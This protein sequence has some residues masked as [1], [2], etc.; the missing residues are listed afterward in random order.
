MMTDYG[1]HAS[2]LVTVA[3]TG[4]TLD[5]VAALLDCN[6]G[7]A[8]YCPACRRWADLDLARLVAQ[9]RGRRRLQGFRPC[10]RKCGQ[11]GQ[12]Q[13]RPPKPTWPSGVTYIGIRDVD[14]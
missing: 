12:I 13:I 7:L 1:L 4:V 8:A 10:C 5:T 6:H 11:P 14:V 3:K 2:A 9:G